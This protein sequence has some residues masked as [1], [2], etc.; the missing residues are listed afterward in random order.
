MG[1]KHACGLCME[2]DRLGG[3]VVNDDM[4]AVSRGDG[5][6]LHYSQLGLHLYRST[7]SVSV[8]LS[9]HFVGV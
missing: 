3:H 4:A 9:M 2:S 8:L 5:G 6:V 7:Q 1:K